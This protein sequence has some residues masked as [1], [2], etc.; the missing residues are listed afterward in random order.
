MD[1]NMAQIRYGYLRVVSKD[2]TH[3]WDK[4]ALS[5]TVSGLYGL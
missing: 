2:I 1:V 4:D 5:F 3:K